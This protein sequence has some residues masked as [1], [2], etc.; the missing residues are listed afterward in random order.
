MRNTILLKVRV[1]WRK[2]VCRCR[3]GR[4]S[5]RNR[6]GRALDSR[7]E[8]GT[9]IVIAIRARARRGRARSRARNRG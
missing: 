3:Q 8:T 4:V 5:R 6:R 9:A 2:S 7:G 1:V